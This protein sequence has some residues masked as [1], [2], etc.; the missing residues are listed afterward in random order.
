MRVSCRLQILMQIIGDYYYAWKKHSN[1]KNCQSIKR[2]ASLARNYT[3]QI[4]LRRRF[5]SDG[6]VKKVK[7]FN[8]CCCSDYSF[9]F[10]CKFFNFNLTVAFHNSND[11]ITEAIIYNLLLRSRWENLE[12]GPNE[13]ASNTL[14][15]KQL[16]QNMHMNKINKVMLS[17]KIASVEKWTIPIAP[18]N[19]FFVDIMIMSWGKR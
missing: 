12:A 6:K 18:Y 10:F 15:L 1:R 19:L 7:K 2:W 16:H 8:F 4:E 5:F 17:K 14:S 9:I 13:Y 3:N 11:E